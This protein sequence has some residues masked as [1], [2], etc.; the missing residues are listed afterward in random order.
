M[1]SQRWLNEGGIFY[2]IVGEI[3]L[4]DTPGPGVW[5]IYQ[6]PNLNDRRLGLVKID[7][8]F[9]FDYKIYNF[10]GQDMFEKI[11]KIWNSDLYVDNNKNLGIIYNGTKGTGNNFAVLLRN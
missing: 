8:K 6:S 2:P 5:Q 10:G 1:A 11:K 7:D 4:H 9:K 3:V